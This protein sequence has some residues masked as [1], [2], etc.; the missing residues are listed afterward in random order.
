METIFF[1]PV[2]F[3]LII[4]LYSAKCFF[5]K[6]NNNHCFGLRVFSVTFYDSTKQFFVYCFLYVFTE[7]FSLIT[8]YIFHIYFKIDL[9]NN[10]SIEKWKR[11]FVDRFRHEQPIEPWF[12]FA[13]SVSVAITKKR[14]RDI[15]WQLSRDGSLILRQ[16]VCCL[17]SCRMPVV[18][19]LL[20]IYF[21]C[22]TCF[23][24]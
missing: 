12:K 16:T 2:L 3:I 14:L 24:K 19:P 11:F 10:A 15:R 23:R 1:Q 21:T 7:T 22:V 8:K 9:P 17:T 13:K 5:S 18:E 20:E 4:F 6:F